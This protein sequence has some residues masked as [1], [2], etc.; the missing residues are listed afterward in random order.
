ME[1]ITLEGVCPDLFAD[2]MI[3]CKAEGWKLHLSGF[4]LSID[5][6]MEDSDHA[7]NRLLAELPQVKDCRVGFES[8]I[9]GPL[10]VK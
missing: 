10:F 8:K 9:R 3:V 4:C 1:I 5:P 7:L 6:V 2:L